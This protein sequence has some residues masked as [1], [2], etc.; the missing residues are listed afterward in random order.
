M[1]SN[2]IKFALNLFIV[3]IIVYETFLEK[4]FYNIIFFYYSIKNSN[5]KIN[6]Y[7]PNMKGEGIFKDSKLLVYNHCFTYFNNT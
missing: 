6:K 3:L 5:R 4:V 7:I 2:F 1:F